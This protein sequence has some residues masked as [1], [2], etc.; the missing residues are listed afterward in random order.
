MT[1]GEQLDAL[2]QSTSTRAWHPIWELLNAFASGET[3]SQW[4]RVEPIAV[5]GE[6]YR[7]LAH[8]SQQQQ[9]AAAPFMEANDA[10]DH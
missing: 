3:Q 6:V 7:M 5:L 4:S 1:S 9:A 2:V 8:L 10:A